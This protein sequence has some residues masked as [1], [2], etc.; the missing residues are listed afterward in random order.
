[1]LDFV[2]SFIVIYIELIIIIHI[3]PLFS[4]S[5]PMSYVGYK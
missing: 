2:W 5:E 3:Q 1:M 4:W